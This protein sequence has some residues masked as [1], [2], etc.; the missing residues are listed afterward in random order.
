MKK[1][2]LSAIVS[3]AL[4]SAAFGQSSVSLQTVPQ[5][6]ALV[7]R[8]ELAGDISFTNV[9]SIRGGVVYLTGMGSAEIE[10]GLGG[11]VALRV[12]PFNSRDLGYQG[13]PHDTRDIGHIGSVFIG[14]GTNVSYMMFAE[15][16]TGGIVLE[17]IGE[18]G[19]RW[20]PFRLFTTFDPP[21]FGTYLLDDLFVDVPLVLSY[22][23]TRFFPDGWTS[24]TSY[25]DRLDSRFS[26][27]RLGISIGLTF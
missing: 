23:L 11:T 9:F 16:P 20:Y 3:L 17:A 18:I 7:G 2:L 10:M 6:G 24:Y 15:E 12:A 5:G 14:A 25:Q 27:I 8:V 1:V 26:P 13:F 21:M 22:G 19:Y 4:S